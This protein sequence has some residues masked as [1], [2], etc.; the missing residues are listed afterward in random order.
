MVFRWR[1]NDGPLIV[2]FGSFFPSSTKKDLSKSDPLWQNFLD[3]HMIPLRHTTKDMTCWKIDR[4]GTARHI[5]RLSCR[6]PYSI[7][8]YL[9][10]PTTRLHLNNPLMSRIRGE[11]FSSYQQR[12]L[13]RCDSTSESIGK[14]AY[15]LSLEIAQLAYN[16]KTTSYQRRCDVVASALKRRCFEV[17]YLLG[18]CS[19]FSSIGRL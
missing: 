8:L 4:Q 7:N 19:K 5:Y 1:T 3:Q 14:I 2:V 13:A 9:S 10:V 17:M 16:L 12:C 6:S 11:P 18:P 15:L